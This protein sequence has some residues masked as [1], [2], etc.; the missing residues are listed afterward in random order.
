M[1]Q[2]IHDSTIVSCVTIAAGAAGTS[3]ITGSTIDF[4]GYRGGLIIVQ[5][6]PIVTGAATSIKFEHSDNANMSGSADVLGTAQTIADDDDNEVF[7]IDLSRPQKRYGRLLVAR[8]TQAATV[9]AVAVLYGANVA[10]TTHATGVQ[11]ET[12]VGKA[13]G[14][15]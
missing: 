14:T 8:A 6:G 12:H 11:G 13:S 15:A 1:S 2:I 9:S 7:F 4:A 5:T 10:P 3:A